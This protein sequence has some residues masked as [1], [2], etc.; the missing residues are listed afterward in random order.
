MIENPL[1][2][3]IETQLIGIIRVSLT[4]PFEHFLDRLK[5]DM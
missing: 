4:M 2:A 5:T 3:I 1:K